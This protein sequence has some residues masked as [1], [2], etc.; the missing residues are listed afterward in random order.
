[1]KRLVYISC[2]FLTLAA[3]AQRTSYFSQYMFN[4]LAINPAY[5]GSHDA[6]S[7]TSLSRMQWLNIEGAPFIQ[8]ISAHSPLKLER[9]AL[10]IQANAESI[11][12]TNNL[13]LLGSFAYWIPTNKGRL[14]FGLQGGLSYFK[15]NYSDLAIKHTPTDLSNV[16]KIDPNLG[17]GFYYYTDRFYLGIASPELLSPSFYNDKIAFAAPLP[18]LFVTSGYLFPISANWKLKPNVLLKTVSGTELTYDLNMNFLFVERLWLGA[19]WSS[20][21][22]VT[23]LV[24]GL[25][26]PQLQIGYAFELPYNALMSQNYGSHELMINYTL[27]YKQSKMLSPRYF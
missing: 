18:H 2:L 16:Q 9:T 13:N 1:M 3:N 21:Q 19:S 15:I 23:L 11:G 12:A 8:S 22:S 24:Q 26:L 20:S 6:W 27:K 7:I 25:V 17:F 14:A 10:G 5:A 4:G